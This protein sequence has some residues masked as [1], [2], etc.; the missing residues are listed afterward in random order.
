MGEQMTHPIIHSYGG[1]YF[2]DRDAER[3]CDGMNDVAAVP[4]C[5]SGA[6]RLEGPY[7]VRALAHVNFIFGWI[8]TKED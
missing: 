4:K 8:V 2:T 1:I 6:L 3:Y 5:P 7:V